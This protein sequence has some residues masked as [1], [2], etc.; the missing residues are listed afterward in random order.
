MTPDDNAEWIDALGDDRPDPLSRTRAHW[1]A[2][3][4]AERELRELN[5]RWVRRGLIAAALVAL[6][7]LACRFTL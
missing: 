7:D 1:Q 6:V 5:Q 4:E 2:C 3:D